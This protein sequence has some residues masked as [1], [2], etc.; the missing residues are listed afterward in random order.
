MTSASADISSLVELVRGIGETDI[1]VLLETYEEIAG[2]PATELLPDI[3][4]PTLVIAGEHD[5]FIPRR[6]TEEL[7]A[8]LPNA[9]L[10]VYED[11]THYLPME[12]PVPLSE[13]LRAFYAR[14]T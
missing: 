9:E 10:L 7:V 2:D 6:M 5:Q 11:A 13:D 8:G 12:H 4:T 3:D 14:V 1:H